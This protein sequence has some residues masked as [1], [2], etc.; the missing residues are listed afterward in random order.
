MDEDFKCLRCK[1]IDRNDKPNCT[2]CHNWLGKRCK[3]HNSLVD[4]HRDN[5]EIEQLMRHDGY[6]RGK[7]GI[8]Q[9]R[10]G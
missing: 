2:N 5:K 10:R 7:G 4:D 3:Y 8:R 6:V 1:P 9:V